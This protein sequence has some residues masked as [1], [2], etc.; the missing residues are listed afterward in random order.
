MTHIVRAGL[1]AYG[2]SGRVFHA[3]LL[4]RHPLFQLAAIC[5]RGSDTARSRYP[6]LPR[7]ASISAL[8]AR[9]DIELVVVN[10]PDTTQYE[11]ARLALEAGKHVVVEKPC[12]GRVD[13]LRA[14]MALA[15]QQKRVLTVFQNRRWDGDFLTVQRLVAAETLGRLVEYEGRWDRFRPE[16][17]RESWKDQAA[18]GSGALNNLGSHLVDQALVLFG[19]PR[20]ITARLGALRDRAEVEDWFNVQLHY[21]RFEAALKVSYLAQHEGPRFVLHGTRGSFVKYGLDP[22]EAALAAGEWPDAAGWGEELR[23][24]WGT[25]SLQGHGGVNRRTVNTLP[26]RYAAFYDGLH[27]AI[28]SGAPVPVPPAQVV[29]VLQILETAR[30]SHAENATIELEQPAP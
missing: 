14:L 19:W 16:V 5:E 18:G 10:T 27:A 13:L 22:Q 24:A 12:T 1:A 21:P 20:A 8:L 17:V 2:M 7:V 28:T 6:D 26:G 4:A 25:L 9:D 3:P 23:A 15:E 11:L 30:R 29:R